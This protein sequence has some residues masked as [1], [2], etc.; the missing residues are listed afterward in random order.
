M[1]HYRVEIVRNLVVREYYLVDADGED[2]AA[3]IAQ[4]ESCYP[5]T[6]DEVENTVE[7]TIV[8]EIA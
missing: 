4:D 3:E 1:V 6:T 2:F 7:E 8:E 5:V